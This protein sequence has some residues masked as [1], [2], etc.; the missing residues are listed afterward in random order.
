MGKRS[1]SYSRRKLPAGLQTA[2][3]SGTRRFFF[4]QS[5]IR[6]ADLAPTGVA[7]ASLDK[8]GRCNLQLPRPEY[9]KGAVVM[10]GYRIRVNAP[11][12]ASIV[13]PSNAQQVKSYALLVK[14]GDD[15][16]PLVITGPA[17]TGATLSFHTTCFYRREQ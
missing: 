1:K 16:A 8:N 4:E 6:D 5:E 14:E 17:D 13:V 11:A 12:E 10:L 3:K 9:E 15:P 2:G 7:S